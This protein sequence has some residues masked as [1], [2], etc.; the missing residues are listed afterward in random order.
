MY[1]NSI[2]RIGISIS[3]VLV[4]VGDDHVILLGDNNGR[5]LVYSCGSDNHGKLGIGSSSNDYRCELVRVHIPND[6]IAIDISAGTHHSSIVSI[7]GRLYTWGS[8]HLFILG[9][10]D[11][12]DHHTPYLVTSL[13]DHHVTRV[14]CGLMHTS[15]VTSN[16]QVYH[17]GVSVDTKQ[18]KKVSLP[19]LP[20]LPLLVLLL[21][22][23]L[24]LLL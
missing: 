14:S 8:G 23:L 17:W 10:G 22:L 16:H 20:L 1:N 4:S 24:L 5:R 15:C 12:D 6:E 9:H 11:C 13:L 2:S 7:D 21:L 18:N 19:L 3:V